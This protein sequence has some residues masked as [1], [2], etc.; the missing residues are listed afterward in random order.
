MLSTE[1]PDPGTLSLSATGYK[2][3]GVWHTDL[4]W[5]YSG[6]VDIYRDGE[7]IVAAINS[8]NGTYTDVTGLKGGGSLNY[9]ICEAG[10]TANCSNE[11]TVQF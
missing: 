2:V 11:V 6:A 10:S 1:E 7:K 8:S 4:S 5:N 9:K 3:K